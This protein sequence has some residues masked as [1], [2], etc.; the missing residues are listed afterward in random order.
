MSSYLS[1]HKWKRMVTTA[2]ANVKR[3]SQHKVARGTLPSGPCSDVQRTHALS[4][5]ASHAS[6][7]SIHRCRNIGA[8]D[9]HHQYKHASVGYSSKAPGTKTWEC[10]P[11]QRRRQLDRPPAQRPPVASAPPSAK[12]QR[13][14]ARAAVVLSRSSPPGR[15]L[16]IRR[17]GA[18]LTRAG[19]CACVVGL[20]WPPRRRS[21]QGL[22]DIEYLHVQIQAK[23]PYET[24][25]ANQGSSCDYSQ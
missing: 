14:T 6:S 11:R 5:L 19:R 20:H 17:L 3:K 10:V 25:A 16:K 23:A 13:W 21:S 12:S 15:E 1:S 2:M 7:S 18:A 22:V 9:K 24:A 4:S 8:G